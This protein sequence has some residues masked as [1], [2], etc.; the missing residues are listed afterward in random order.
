MSSWKRGRCG[1]RSAVVRSCFPNGS[2]RIYDIKKKRTERVDGLVDAG[3]PGVAVGGDVAGVIRVAVECGV[4]ADPGVGVRRR[5]RRAGDGGS[6]QGV[7][8]RPRRRRGYRDELRD[9]RRFFDRDLPFRRH[10]AD[11]AEAVRLHRAAGHAKTDLL[12]QVFADCDP[13]ADRDFVA[14]PDSGAYRIHSGADSAAAAGIRAD[15]PGPAYG[16]LY[17]DFRPDHSLHGAAGGLR[18]NLYQ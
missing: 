15:P 6:G 17:P 4:F 9:A 3:Q 18:E 10:R 5:D 12:F 14:E 2:V 1:V 13:D 16:G 8:R 7:L 11:R